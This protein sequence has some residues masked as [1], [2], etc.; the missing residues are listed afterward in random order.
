MTAI[1]RWI[2]NSW[3]GQ[4]GMF[5]STYWQY[6]NGYGPTAVTLHDLGNGTI[7]LQ[8]PENSGLGIPAAFVSVRSD[9]F[10]ELNFQ[11]LNGNWIT[12]IGPAETF[13]AIPTGDGDG[14]FALYSPS[15]GRYV[16]FLPYG[17]HDSPGPLSANP[18]GT[19]GPGNG[20]TATGLDRSSV[21]DLRQVYGN[22][23]G[24]SLVNANL[25]GADL[26]GCDFRSISPSSL[27]G[28]VLDGAKLQYASFAGLHLDGLSISNADCTYA[29]FSGCDF[30][31]FV[32]GTPPPVLANADLTGAMIPA[33][34]SWSGANMPGAVLAEATLGC[35]LSGAATNLVGA[36]LSGVGVKL[37]EPAYQGGAIGKDNLMDRVI[38]F[39]CNSTGNLDHLVCYVPGTGSVII[40]RKNSDGT[41]DTVYFQGIPGNGIGGYDLKNPADRIIAYDYLGTGNLDHL[42]CYRPGTGTIWILEKTTDSNNTVTFDKVWDSTS[43][44]GGSQGCDLSDPN[45]RIIAYDYAGTGNLDHLVCYRRGTANI[46]ILE[47][48][49]DQNNDVTFTPVFTS[50]GGIGADNTMD[51]VIAFDCNSTGNL[52]HLVCYIPGAGSVIIVRKNSDGTF[53]TVYFQG[54]PGT[55]IGGYKLDN[56]A[57]RIIAYD[58]LGTGHLDHLVC[59]RPGTG[60]IWILKKATDQN[61]NV[62]F[63]PVYCRFGIGGYDLA[64]PADRIIA[65]DHNSTGHLDD[66]VCYRPNTSTIWVIQGR[67]AGPATLERCNVTSANLS[68]A[69]LAGAK[70]AGVNLTGANLAATNFTGADLTEVTFS[71]PLIRSTDP[72]NP[73]IFASCI[74]PY[75]GIGLDWSCLD[76]TAATITGLPSDLT[77]LVAVGVRRPEGNFTDFILD[78]ANFAN[79]TLDGAAFNG[80]KL[81]K[82]SFAE[83]RL[84]GASF[85]SAVLDQ[86]NFTGA[87]LG[88]IELT[89]AANFSSARI[90]NC[91]FTQANAYGVNFAGATLVSDNTLTDAS[92]QESDFSDAYLPYADFTGAN[93]QGAKFDGA[94]MVECVLKS[95]DLTPA[96][97]GAIAASLNK[98]CLQS[99]NFTGT[100]LGGANLNNAAITNDAGS[101]QVTHYDEYGNLITDS[102]SWQ[103]SSFPSEAA[104]SDAT[105]CPNGNTYGWNKEQGNSIVTMMQAQNP[106]T[107]W[108][109]IDL[110]KG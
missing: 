9:R 44:I 6:G 43:G 89:Q 67:P 93:L 94:C 36:N 33:G 107:Q 27:S 66:L 1:N 14:S 78:G 5:Q 19:P 15:F 108:P 52:D 58:Y 38:A 95:A 68:G 99:V 60:T 105:T 49:T 62:T 55:G 79:A 31:S 104:L 47:K 98:A 30:T 23:A 63:T 100:N 64:V 21:L 32:P 35:D 84:T 12:E 71:F 90:S 46:R 87:A 2:L 56:P 20:F 75:A 57:D 17:A 16:M 102:I 24:V 54:D 80:A 48:N 96:Q 45:D 110:Y 81:Q 65:Y 10:Y 109:P 26:S 106:P 51:R 86:A 97:Q 72:N 77:G 41:F 74:L 40:V 25:S 18:P 4:T 13:Q 50:T 61:N 59:Y 3:A 42:V 69:Q 91:N 103:A 7:A 28:C 76:L 53:D 8:C 39:D 83:A 92:L 70:L 85:T 22:L 11:D 88:G 101:I 82:A 29:D 37:F 34:N 73:T